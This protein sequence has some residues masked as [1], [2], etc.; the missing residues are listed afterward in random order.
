MRQS[1]PFEVWYRDPI[2]LEFKNHLYNYLVRKHEIQNTLPHSREGFTLEIGSGVSPIC[3]R[4]DRVIHS[5]P[6]ESAMKYLMVERLTTRALTMSA[7]DIPLRNESVAT[8]VCSEVLEHI[9]DDERALQEMSRIIRPGGELILTVPIHQYY[10]AYD[11][12]FVKHERRYH[13]EI[14]LQREKH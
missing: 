3:T 9:R 5:D 4:G 12:R 6:A 14:F 10:Y 11:D 7:T 2:F 8:V 1:N 13:T